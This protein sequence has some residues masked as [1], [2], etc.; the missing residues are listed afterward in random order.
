MNKERKRCKATT[1]AGENC[2][3][4]AQLGSTFCH[5]HQAQKEEPDPNLARQAE[6][7]RY[8]MR[9]EF[10]YMGKQVR[11][12]MNQDGDKATIFIDDPEF[13][14]MMHTAGKPE[15]NYIKLWM[16]KGA[17]TMTETPELMAKH[18][19]EYWHQFN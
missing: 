18:I 19:I 16:C 12:K 7:G 9:D 2:K 14:V 10:T 3:N 1:Q 13:E 17:Y 8:P 15:D 6:K 5:V 11:I 4:Y